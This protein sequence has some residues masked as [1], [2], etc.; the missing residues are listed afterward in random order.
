MWPGHQNAAL[1]LLILL[2]LHA[3]PSVALRCYYCFGVDDCKGSMASVSCPASGYSD[4]CLKKN[5]DGKVIARDCAP[6]PDLHYPCTTGVDGVETCVCKGYL[7][8]SVANV[9]SFRELISLFLC[10]ALYA[11]YHR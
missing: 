1:I 3:A 10:V 9:S 11:S 4:G 7:C 5:K 2:S 8:N 6:G